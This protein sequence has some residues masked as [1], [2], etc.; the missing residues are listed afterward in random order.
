MYPKIL[1]V[2]PTYSGKDYCLEKYLKHVANINYPNK[3]H[4]IVD[5]TQDD[6]EYT[7]KL[8]G[9]GIETYHVDRGSNS[10]DALCD[11]MNLA[12]KYFLENSYDYMFILESD[13]F[14][15]EDII[16]RLMSY[17][18]SVVGS[19]YLIGHEA[20][21]HKYTDARKE[22]IEGRISKEEF[23]KRITNVHPQRACIFYLDRKETGAL[24]TRN[25]SPKETYKLFGNG[26]QQV[27][28]CG[29][30]AT[31]IRRDV[32]DRFPF[33]TDTRFG[34]KHHD[35]YFYMD[36]HN[37]GIK[38]YVDTDNLIKHSPSKWDDV[39]DM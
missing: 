9:L 22:W 33:W 35:V 30:G 19:F 17:Q 32:I 23:R 31:L 8:K 37:K 4:I 10:R 38:V 26:L 27:H 2:T 7:K 24:G 3:H 21:N 25:I 5:N 29:L 28:G 14:P 11:S 18:K 36:L 1:I 20:D 6:G 13:L 34:N 39:E 12:R 16:F 15:E